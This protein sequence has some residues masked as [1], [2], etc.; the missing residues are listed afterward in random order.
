MTFHTINVSRSV[1]GAI[2]TGTVRQME[3]ALNHIHMTNGN[4]ELETALKK[5]AE[6]V[7]AEGALTIDAKNEILQ[8]LTALA[9]EIA[10]PNESRMMGVIKAFVVS[11]AAN[12]ASSPLV[13]HWQNIM[14]LLGL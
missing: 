7:L 11:I 2:N 3:V 9:E 5:F 12:I 6:D 14:H 8:Q 4:P 1:V 10:K 13:A